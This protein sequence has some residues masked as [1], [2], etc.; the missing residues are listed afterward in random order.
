MVHDRLDIRLISTASNTFNHQRK[1][2]RILLCHLLFLRAHPLELV[3]WNP[4]VL[5]FPALPVLSETLSFGL[6]DAREHAHLHNDLAWVS[7]RH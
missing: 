2:E 6:R 1:L 4:I 7:G 5:A 3:D